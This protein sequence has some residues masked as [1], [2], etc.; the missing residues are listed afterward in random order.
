MAMISLLD[1][2]LFG[3]Q[4]KLK[5]L[6]PVINRRYFQLHVIFMAVHVICLYG[7]C[8]MTGEAR[9]IMADPYVMA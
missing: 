2:F 9:P 6:S 4:N 7:L 5:L 8:Y 1:K 3:F